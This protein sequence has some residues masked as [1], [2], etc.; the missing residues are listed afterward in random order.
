M[1][2]QGI[3]GRRDP[4]TPLL[5]LGF[6]VFPLGGLSKVPKKDFRWSEYQTR[7]PTAEEIHD[8]RFHRP[9]ANVGVVTGEISDLI[10]VDLDGE[11]GLKEFMRFVNKDIATPIVQTRKGLHL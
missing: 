2:A 4:Y 3:V 1:M 9:F 11:K 6:S 10:V 7:K 8:W 5:N